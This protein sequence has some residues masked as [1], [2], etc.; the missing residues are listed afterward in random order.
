MKLEKIDLTAL[1]K[2]YSIYIPSMQ[3]GAAASLVMPAEDWQSAA[4]PAGLEPRD[5]NFLREDNRFWSYKYALASAAN[6]RGNTKNAIAHRDGKEHVLGDSGGFQVGTGA[7]TG[8][9][10]WLG[11]PQQEVMER[12]R[13]SNMLDEITKWCE[14]NC[15][16]AMT[17]DIPLWVNRPSSKKN[18]NKSPFAGFSTEA[19]LK[20]SVENLQYLTDK[21]GTWTN[22]RHSCK[23]LNVLQGESIEQEQLWFDAVK[24]FKLDGWSLAGQVG[25]D[26][27]PYRI[28]NRLLKLADAGLLGSGYDWVHLLKLGKLR[29]APVVTALQYALRKKVNKK[30]TITYDSSSAYMSSGRFEGYYSSRELTGDISTWSHSANKFPSTWGYANSPNSMR[31]DRVKCRGAKKC[32]M[33][34]QGKLHLPEPMTSPIASLMT[35]QDMFVRTQGLAQ[36]RVGKLFE[37][38]LANNNVFVIVEGMIRANEAVFGEMPY[39][40]QEIMDACGLIGEIVGKEDWAGRLSKHL[41]QLESAVGYKPKKQSDAPEVH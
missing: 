27:G 17:L 37:A 25:V 2:D 33:C 26:G 21:R 11:L 3:Q 12:W 28:I 31:M 6:F 18:P 7:F 4:L 30:L 5:F 15:D 36:R 34:E 29:W 20:L 39:A 13:D 14:L 32:V 10:K 23:Y 22:G 38:T 41:P 24:G 40:P 16:Y 1:N 19:L 9:D 35:V 8:A